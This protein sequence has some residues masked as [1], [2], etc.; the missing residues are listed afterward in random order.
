VEL[1]YSERNGIGLYIILLIYKILKKFAS[2]LLIGNVIMGVF[3][4]FRNGVQYIT[5]IDTALTNLNKV[6]DETTE[7]LKEFS[8]EANKIG[9]NLA[10]TTDAVI[11]S[12]TEFARLGYS[13]KEASIL[14]QQALL[15]SNVGDIDEVTASTNLI[16]A[17]KGFGI[18]VDAVG[19][20][21]QNVVDIYNEVGN[22]FAISSAGIGEAMARSAASLYGAGNTIE[23][24]VAMITAANAVIQNPNN[25]GT[26]LKTVSMRLRGIADEGE[27]LEEDLVPKLREAFNK[28]GLEILDNND[29]FKSTYDIMNDLAGIWDTLTDVQR[30]N[31]TELVAGKRQGNIVVSM[32]NNWKDAEDALIASLMSENS[33]IIENE[34]YM[35][36]IEAKKSQFINTVQGAW[37]KGLDSEVIKDFVV[38]ATTLVR[39]FGNLPSIITLA[40]TALLVFKGQAIIGSIVSIAQLVSSLTVVATSIEATTLATVGLGKAF[41]ILKLKMASNPLGLIAVGFTT[42]AAAV[43]LAKDNTEQLTKSMSEQLNE[44]V[45][46]IDNNKK[47]VQVLEILK[48]KQERLNA[49]IKSGSLS[50]EELV[51]KEKELKDV[52]EK[53]NL[54]ITDEIKQKM[55]LNGVR[56]SEIDKIIEII[57]ERNNE[58]SNQY[59]T[60]LTMSQNAISGA[61]TRIAAYQEELEALKALQTAQGNQLKE[62]YGT[63]GEIQSDKAKRIGN[64]G[65]FETV[66]YMATDLISV[67]PSLVKDTEEYNKTTKRI[68]ELE[69]KLKN[70]NKIIEDSEKI[71]SD[72]LDNLNNLESNLSDTPSSGSSSG[73]GSSYISDQYAISLAKLDNQLKVLEYTKSKLSTTS[74]EYRNVLAKELDIYKQ[75]QQLAHE[76]ADRLRGLQAQ[77]S[78]GTE[79]YDKYTKSIQ[80]LQSTWLDL[81]STIDD[82]KIAQFTSR[83]EESDIAI[84]NTTDELEKVQTQLSHLT[85]GTEL[86]NKKEQQLID[87]TKENI[88]EL[89]SKQLL[90]QKEI[91]LETE[92]IARKNDLVES[93]KQVNTELFNTRIALIELQRQQEITALESERDAKLDA[94]NKKIEAIDK[95]INSIKKL[96][97]TLQRE[98]EIEDSILAISKAQLEIDK[99]QDNLQKAKTKLANVQNEK[100]TRIFQNGRFEYIADPEAVRNAL[101]EVENAKDSVKS[102]NEALISAQE[103]YNS[104]MQNLY[105]AD[106]EAKK[107]AEQEKQKEINASFDEQKK[108]IDGYYDTLI[109][110]IPVQGEEINTAM[111]EVLR[112]LEITFGTR[113]KNISETVI[114]YIKD[115]KRELLSFAEE[116]GTTLNLSNLNLSDKKIEGY[117]TGG[118]IPQ[119]KIAQLHANEYVLNSATVNSLGGKSGVESM[120][121]SLRFPE[122]VSAKVIQSTSNNSSSI[123]KSVK[124]NNLN[125]PSVVDINGF[126]RNI[127]ALA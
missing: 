29:T 28:L 27:E 108:M 21:V 86:Y 5:D 42:I 80:D 34:K 58:L 112:I 123:D 48:A 111:D 120:I 117:A 82:N 51:E 22:N 98:K 49:E 116:T 99:A 9:N 88:K 93:L 72:S 62:K 69:N 125:L 2:W 10:R 36:S 61:K 78:Q 54:V 71:L 114:D 107:T 60:Q 77:V 20:N 115:M 52:A 33:A 87:L 30:A 97:E 65:F 1:K 24:A 68:K 35:N 41:D 96:N 90:Y 39:V 121:S 16:S 66:K 4:A 124:I 7:N 57:N 79:E 126:V 12:T 53:I 106:L 15:Y 74:E 92:N 67:N 113:F 103:S 102:A 95:E 119:N 73:S 43:M 83:V 40:T 38:A 31:I 32:L 13:L 17:I 91:A 81:Q 101:K 105:L 11:N 94:S 19:R 104:T 118:Y 56:D 3:G 122:L 110:A 85:S 8:L 84:A 100:N 55:E 37:Q 44:Q 109:A 6:T 18:E 70:D 64:A 89:E 46:V 26:A 14:A 23:E 25:V 75:K 76:E 45:K 127:K 59:T 63:I 50:T 47:R